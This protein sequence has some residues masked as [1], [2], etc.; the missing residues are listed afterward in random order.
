[1]KGNKHNKISE[2]YYRNS[3]REQETRR[4][5][6]D[7][8]VFQEFRAT[9][10][11]FIKIKILYIWQKMGLKVM[12]QFYG[13]KDDIFALSKHFFSQGGAPGGPLKNLNFFRGYIFL[14]AHKHPNK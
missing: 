13:I 3:F 1:M 9:N 7:D 12:G 5:K 4:Q 14:G 8:F 11:G 10:L 6:C 2:Q